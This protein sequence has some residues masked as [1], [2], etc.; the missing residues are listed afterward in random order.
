MAI[1]PAVPARDARACAAIYAPYVRETPISF[2]EV[3]PTADE[4]AAR[5]RRVIE[6][7]PWLVCERGGVV[8][9]YAYA[10]EH[11][12]RAA[13]R[14]SAE[15]AIYIHRDHHRQGV[16]RALYAELLERLRAQGFRAAFGGI[17]LP[18]A[19]SVALH[20]A[21]GFRPIGVYRAIGWKAGAWH[22]VGWWQ[23]DLLP[24]GP[25]PPL[26]LRPPAR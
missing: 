19:G 22:D 6:T 9:G 4:M 3:A 11:R 26:P 7:H 5:M 8:V 24:A 13:Y 20:E 18:N 17:T 1:R 2:E 16:G 14:W 25:E 15:V 12:A 23:L 10:S 21:M